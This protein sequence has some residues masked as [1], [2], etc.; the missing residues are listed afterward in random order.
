MDALEDLVTRY[1]AFEGNRFW[2]SM[3]QTQSIKIEQV[4]DK[5][6]R[7][8]ICMIVSPKWWLEVGVQLVIC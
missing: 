3:L 7:L 8:F 5:Q 2:Q 1:G 6:C 4:M